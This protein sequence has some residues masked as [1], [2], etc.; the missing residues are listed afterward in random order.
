VKNRLPDDASDP[1]MQRFDP[2]SWPHQEHRPGG[3][4]RRETLRR[5][6]LDY[7]QAELEQW[8]A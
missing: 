3:Q 5:V 8:T 7:V 2:S 4:R 6:A 1:R